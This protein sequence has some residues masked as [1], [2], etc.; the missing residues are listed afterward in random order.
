[1]SVS[2]IN[3]TLYCDIKKVWDVVTDVRNYPTWR[4]DLSKTEIL[5]EYQFIEYTK[6]GYATTFTITLTKPYKQWEFDMD[7]SNISGHWVGV[8]SQ[9]GDI[10]TVAFTENVN[11]KK[12]FL[13]T[14]VR[15]YLRKQQ[16]QFIADLKLNLHRKEE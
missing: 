6:S 14:F 4:S 3:A 9:D 2:S 8:F 16:K 10:T 15:S 1:M 7:N 5:N 12:W 11:T 13:K